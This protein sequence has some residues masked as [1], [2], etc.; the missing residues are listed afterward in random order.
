[1]W[2][3]CG[4]GTGMMLLVSG[5]PEEWSVLERPEL[6]LGF[7]VTTKTGY[8]PPRVFAVTKVWG[9]DN[10]CIDGLDRPRFEK[11]LRMWHGV[12]PGPLWVNAPDV[13][14]DAKQTQERF[15]EWEPILHKMGF[16]VAF[17]LQDGQT[18]D[19]MPWSRLEAV[20]V[21]GSTKFK[22][23]YE[24][25]QLCQEA[26]ARGK[27]I[28]FG[29]VNTK[30]RME[31]VL[32]FGADTIDGSGFSRWKSRITGGVQWIKRA[33]WLVANQQELF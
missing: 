27:L 23:G 10:D 6:P 12:S 30:C 8:T 28:H 31:I 16:P 4:K 29:R 20:F 13:V 9:M 24:A 33:K 3:V 18:P 1:M 32:R 14:G 5:L 11:T 19:R 15:E 2:G 25:Y 26:K 17:T 7:L 21:G 22:L